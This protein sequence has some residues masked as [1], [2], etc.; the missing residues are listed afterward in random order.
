[1][2]GRSDSLVLDVRS[3]V[4]RRELHSAVIR[5]GVWKSGAVFRKGQC[6]VMHDMVQ[7]CE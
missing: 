6:S 4:E 2:C 7:Y 5:K 3:A 1:M